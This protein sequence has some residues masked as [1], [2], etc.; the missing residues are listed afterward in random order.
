[1]LTSGGFID[2]GY[3]LF[4]FDLKKIGWPG[5]D[6]GG[7]DMDCGVYVCWYISQ[8]IIKWKEYRIKY[9]PNQYSFATCKWIDIDLACPKRSS[10]WFADG[11]LDCDLFRLQ[12][13][14]IIIRSD[15]SWLLNPWKEIMDG[16]PPISNDHSRQY[17][18]DVK[19][20]GMTNAATNGVK[21]F[22]IDSASSTSSESSQQ[23]SLSGKVTDSSLTRIKDTFQGKGTRYINQLQSDDLFHSVFD[24]TPISIHASKYILSLLNKHLKEVCL[25][26]GKIMI[27][28]ESMITL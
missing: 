13:A 5:Q 10:T 8:I 16:V 21:K 4:K 12:M 11:I 24:N 19:K 15:L 1:M 20:N 9:R 17:L 23:S 3:S 26:I 27:T 22:V 28:F 6:E 14:D 7:K 25:T 18:D 2:S